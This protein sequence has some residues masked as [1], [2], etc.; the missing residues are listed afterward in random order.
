MTNRFS[1]KLVRL[2]AK[3]KAVARECLERSRRIFGF[4]PRNQPPAASPSETDHGKIQEAERLDRLRN[5][6]NY[7]GR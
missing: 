3:T 7:R 1:A 2:S 4:Q 6:G 5:P